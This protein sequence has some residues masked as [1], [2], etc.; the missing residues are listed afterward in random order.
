M[1][2]ILLLLLVLLTFIPQVF[3]CAYKPEPISTTLG[4]IL[5]LIGSIIT[6]ISILILIISIFSKIK[7]ES[8]RK[9]GKTLF[10]IGIILLLIC[11]TLVIILPLTFPPSC[12]PPA[13]AQIAHTL[14]QNY[15]GF[16]RTQEFILGPGEI[17]TSKDFARDYGFRPES[18]IFYG[19]EFELSEK[20]ESG[21]NTTD[22]TP[23]S[24]IKS[25]SKT[26]TRARAMILCARNGEELL[27][28]LVV[29][30]E[31]NNELGKNKPDTSLCTNNY[32]EPCCA[33][34]LV[35]K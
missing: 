28:T 6:S 10:K 18:I 22:T 31:G 7:K 19:G 13:Q 3:A 17:I 14:S 16:M 29:F 20:M 34:V 4:N 32:A 24:Y 5:F 30:Q 27:K 12:S 15:A 25:I 2:K 11:F 33:V 8:I 35:R 9:K 1:K 23:F 21:I 26:P